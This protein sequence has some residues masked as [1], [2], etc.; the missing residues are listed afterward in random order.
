MRVLSIQRKAWGHMELSFV[1]L[2]QR[3]GRE[4]DSPKPQREATVLVLPR[5]SPP[6]AVTSLLFR[7]LSIAFLIPTNSSPPPAA[8]LLP[9]MG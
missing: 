3:W 2:G 1:T 5:P 6:P 9:E 7:L 4:V 8:Q